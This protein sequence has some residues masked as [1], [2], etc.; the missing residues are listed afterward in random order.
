MG[1]SAAELAAQVDPD[2]VLT[3]GPRYGEARRIWNGAVDQRP[4]VIVRA[5]TPAEVQA[6]I[7]VA[8]QYH[9][10]VR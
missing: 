10:L 9:L 5:E 4:A 3:S 7:Q 8:R 6:A 1:T 2:R